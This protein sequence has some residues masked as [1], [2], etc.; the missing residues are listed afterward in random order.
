M[1]ETAQVRQQPP[2]Q[3]RS[4]SS[5][6]QLLSRNQ[7]VSQSTV[8]QRPERSGTIGSINHNRNL[9]GAGQNSVSDYGDSQGLTMRKH[10]YDLQS[11]ETSL[12]SPRGGPKSTI[13]PPLV[14][15]KSEFPTLTRSRE[16]QSLTC[17]VTVEVNQPKWKPPMNIDSMP[18]LP[19]GGASD[20]GSLKS[21]PAHR[22]TNSTQS[23]A[24]E[25]LDRITE[26]LRNRVDNWHG[27]DFQRCAYWHDF[28]L[29]S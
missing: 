6:E 22:R 10:D 7:S 28:L 26:E 19:L 29:Q 5:Q 1:P 16:Q 14:T 12:A 3:L 27:L 18:P 4:Q 17:L 15:V 8:S 25:E 21:P 9:S 20:Y 13:L 23:E 11:M 2:H 24:P